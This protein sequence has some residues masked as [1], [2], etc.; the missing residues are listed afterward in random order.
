MILTTNITELVLHLQKEAGVFSTPMKKVDKSDSHIS[1]EEITSKLSMLMA[2]PSSVKVSSRQAAR[3]HNAMDRDSDSDQENEDRDVDRNI[4]CAAPFKKRNPQNICKPS[5]RKAALT[6]SATTDMN[7]QTP[8][9]TTNDSKTEDSAYD[10]PWTPEEKNAAK[11]KGRGQRGRGRKRNTEKPRHATDTEAQEFRLSLPGDDS[12]DRQSA[13]RIPRPLRK[14][15]LQDTPPSNKLLTR[16]SG[17]AYLGA[18]I[19][20]SN[21]I[22]QTYILKELS[23]DTNQGILNQ[24]SKNHNIIENTHTP[25]DA[26]IA[27]E[28]SSEKNHTKKDARNRKS[29]EHTTKSLLPRKTRRSNDDLVDNS[30]VSKKTAT[31]SKGENLPPKKTQG[32][33]ANE[34]FLQKKNSCQQNTQSKDELAPKST[35]SRKKMNGL[36]SP[37]KTRLTRARTAKTEEDR[38]SSEDS[39]CMDLSVSL[40][41]IEDDEESNDD[42]WGCELNSSP[43][44]CEH[45]ST[46]PLREPLF[47][48]K[49]CEETM[50]L[51]LIGL[52][53]VPEI[54]VC[55]DFLQIKTEVPNGKIRDYTNEPIEISRADDKPT[56]SKRGKSRKGPFEV[57]QDAPE[58][59]RVTKLKEKKKSSV[60]FSVTDSVMQ[61]EEISVA[62]DNTKRGK[63]FYMDAVIK[64]KGA[65]ILFVIYSIWKYTAHKLF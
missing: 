58:K 1:V 61:T 41:S 54:T 15:P 24:H 27:T 35:D 52:E 36:I 7:I 43:H 40:L 30:L 47:K 4:S 57:Y 25:K 12:S 18:K 10:L 42:T 19:S 2:T 51:D 21:H 39:E 6:K 9:K 13:S 62:D 29:N 38:N 8:L 33:Q 49:T 34:K 63:S 53:P 48:P 11:V 65:N 22:K 16:R 17:E 44:M 56:G 23:S 32:C 60:N 46:L 31:R 20:P 28:S 14:S 45:G 55:Q 64:V 37:R 3:L 26:K 59:P 5:L 50:L